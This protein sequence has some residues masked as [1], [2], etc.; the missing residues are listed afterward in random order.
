VIEKSLNKRRNTIQKLD[1]EALKLAA[2]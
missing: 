2:Q 1:E